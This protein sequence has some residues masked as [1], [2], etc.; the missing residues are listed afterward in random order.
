MEVGKSG[1]YFTPKKAQDIDNLKIFKG[2]CSTFQEL[3]RGMFLRV[4][5]ARK[6][7]RK[8]TVLEAINALYQTHS[9]K[10]KE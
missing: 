10:D 9:D 5:T 8:D 4:D 6:I 3:E 1:K 7:V 2:Y